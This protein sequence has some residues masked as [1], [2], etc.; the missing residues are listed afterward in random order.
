MSIWAIGRLDKD[1]DRS[2]FDCGQPMLNEW[3]KDRAGQFDRRDLSRTFVAPRSDEAIVLGYYA[4]STH[5]VVYD[6]L[7][8]A[9]SKGLPRLD[10]PVVLIG[11]L[12]VDQSVQ[13]QGLGALLLV[14]ALRRS[15]QISEQVGI[16]ALEVDALDNAAKN[17]YLKFGFRSLRDDPRHLFLPIHEIR[18][19]KLD[20]L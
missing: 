14:D 10:V 13:G 20:P 9:E 11:R 5:R 2:V 15:L 4:I 19:L 1:H 17:F 7:P 6:A 12:A 3:L 8:A 16:R 18:K